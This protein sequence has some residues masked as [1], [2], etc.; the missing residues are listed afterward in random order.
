MYCIFFRE[1][2]CSQ[3]CGGGWQL[4][5]R[6]CNNPPPQNGGKQCE[7]YPQE[8]R[9]CNDRPCDVHK[10]TYKWN[11]KW[12]CVRGIEYEIPDCVNDQNQV[13]QHGYCSYPRPNDTRPCNNHQHV[14]KFVIKISIIYKL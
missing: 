8:K 10:P 3:T 4:F 14:F 6:E 5:S 12:T 9:K 1:S 7:G 13:V 11:S 2:E